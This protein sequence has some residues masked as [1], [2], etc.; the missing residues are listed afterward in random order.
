[1]SVRLVLSTF[2]PL[3]NQMQMAR[4]KAHRLVPNNCLKLSR[5]LLSR[6]EVRVMDKNHVT[7][8]FWLRL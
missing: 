1:M 8:D 7:L 6:S 3:D 2:D 5:P 4:R